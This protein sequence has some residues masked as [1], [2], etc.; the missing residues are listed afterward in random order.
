M[1]QQLAINLKKLIWREKIPP[2]RHTAEEL[3]VFKQDAIEN[4][5][6]HY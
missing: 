1:L 2:P 5:K 3:E 6:K 4:K